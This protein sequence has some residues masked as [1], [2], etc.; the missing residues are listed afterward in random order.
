[1]ESG[2]QIKLL[3]ET[4]QAR[5]CADKMEVERLRGDVN[6]QLSMIERLTGLKCVGVRNSGLA[7][8]FKKT[9]QHD[10]NCYCYFY[11]GFCVFC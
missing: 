8:D 5:E 10:G 3:Q 1:V 7:F 9:G 11:F 2:E 6:A 4:Q